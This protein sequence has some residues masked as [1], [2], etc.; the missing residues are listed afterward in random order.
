[1][2]V[3]CIGEFRSGHLEGKGCYVYAI[4]DRYEGSFVHGI[5]HGEGKYTYKD[6][7]WY[8]GEYLNKKKRLLGGF[9]SKEFP[10]L[11]G[12]RHGFGIRMF[13]NGNKYEG[14]W[15]K[16]MMHSEVSI[17]HKADGSKYEGGFRHNQRHGKNCMEQFGNKLDKD[18]ICPMGH[19]H[20]G[21]GY[22]VY[23]GD[24]ARDM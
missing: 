21:E 11:D 23:T 3:C 9:N 20:A 19:K 6:G 17:L 10:V 2:S 5:F 18:Y 7:S 16:G 22:C 13:V 1:M 15:L 4:G 8:S 12:I 14:K 24:Y